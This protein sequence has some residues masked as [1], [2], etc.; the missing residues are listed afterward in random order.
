MD[1]NEGSVSL[2]LED[3]TGFSQPLGPSDLNGTGDSSY[4][5]GATSFLSSADL[6][7]DT[8]D[9]VGD[10][11]SDG[12]SRRTPSIVGKCCRCETDLSYPLVGVKFKIGMNEIPVPK[13]YPK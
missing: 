4:E 13:K 10:D 9:L 2:S 5:D 6:S 1:S 11:A 7:H 3:L 8:F 12:Y